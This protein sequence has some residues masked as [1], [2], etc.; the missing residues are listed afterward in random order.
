MWRI[1]NATTAREIALTTDATRVLAAALLALSFGNGCAGQN[2]RRG[3]EPQLGAHEERSELA[4]QHGPT[5]MEFVEILEAAYEFKVGFDA[6]QVKAWD[7]ERMSPW[8]NDDAV[9]FSDVNAPGPVRLTKAELL[10]Q[11]KAREG[12]AHVEFAHIAYLAEKPRSG[13]YKIGES[14]DERGGSVVT[15]DE[16]YRLVFRRV[17]NRLVLES[18]AYLKYEVE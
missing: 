15:L 11:L 4:K 6:R 14:V 8:L 16:D 12:P 18:C 3:V 2:E 1:F 10:Q 17:G 7:I 9:T 5:G 13:S